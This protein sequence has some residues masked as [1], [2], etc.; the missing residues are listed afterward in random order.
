MQSYIPIQRQAELHK[1]MR[2]I[3]DDYYYLSLISA[4]KSNSIAILCYNLLVFPLFFMPVKRIACY[5]CTMKRFLLI[6]IAAIFCSSATVCAQFNT[7]TQTKVHRKAVPKRHQSATSE[8]LPPC[9]PHQRRGLWSLPHYKPKRRADRPPH[10]T[11]QSTPSYLCHQ[12]FRLPQ[13]PIYKEKP[14]TTGF[15]LRKVKL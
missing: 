15:G 7:V 11:C 4:Q 13:R 2:V 5:F 12:P 14:Y 6:T 3:F 10:G 8:Q 9:S 1:I